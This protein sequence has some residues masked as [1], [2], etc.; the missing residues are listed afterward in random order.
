M[1]LEFEKTYDLIRVYFNSRSDYPLIWSVDDG[2]QANE[3]N[4]PHVI[5]QGICRYSGSGKKPNA[6][7]PVAWAEYRQARL[8]RIDDSEEVFVENS[9]E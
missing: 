7:S 9:S 4:V 1:A 8:H 6:V 3:I 2:N 5:T